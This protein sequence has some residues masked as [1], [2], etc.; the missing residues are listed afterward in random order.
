MHDWRA[1]FNRLEGA[2]APSTIQSYHSDLGAY[3]RWC[4]RSGVA[5]FPATSEQVCAFLE[6]D[7]RRSAASTVQRRLYA[8]RK[9]HRLLNLPDPTHDEDINLT[10][11]RIRRLKHIRPTQAKGMTEAYLR[12]FIATEPDTPTG[13]RNRAM[14]SLVFAT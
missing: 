4:V 5:M 14:M 2:Y 3:E 1:E 11:R 8:I 12:A 9:A 6:Q 13:I 7:A 10:L